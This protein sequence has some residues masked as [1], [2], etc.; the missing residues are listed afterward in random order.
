M[1]G[2]HMQHVLKLPFITQRQDGVN[3][4][5]EGKQEGS[6]GSCLEG[7]EVKENQK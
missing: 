6:Q 5:Q 2:K 1:D 4:S 7:L 3:I